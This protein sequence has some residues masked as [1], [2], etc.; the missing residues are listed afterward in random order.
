[1][2]LVHGARG[3]AYRVCESPVGGAVK[4]AMDVVLAAGA[5]MVLALPL[6]FI[7]LLIR[8]ES[9]GP[10][11]FCQW[12]AGY[13]GRAFRIYKLRTMST[14]DDGRHIRQ[15]T[16]GDARVTKLGR[17]L[18]RTSIDE[19]P[20]LINVLNGDMSIVGPRPH[21]VAHEYEFK[22]A[23]RDYAMRRMARPGLTGL[24]QVS[25]ARGLTDTPEKLA[26]R[27][28]LDMAYIDRWSLALD[29]AIMARTVRVLVGD[30]AAF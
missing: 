3:A 24:A 17:F 27:I 12:R 15:A 2:H 6:L 16:Q 30:R 14:R 18:R 23:D 10:A 9:R 26:R 20:Q 22:R 19:L 21:A 4:R 8:L 11:I 13:R 29:L 1:M 5:L 7:A 28:E 25:G